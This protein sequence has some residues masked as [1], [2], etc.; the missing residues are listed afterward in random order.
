MNDDAARLYNIQPHQRANAILREIF[1]VFPLKRAIKNGVTARFRSIS[2]LSDG[3]QKTI[4][5]AKF[6]EDSNRVC[7]G[8]R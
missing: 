8:L 6:G 7:S 5:R 3:D 2:L 4:L 1:G